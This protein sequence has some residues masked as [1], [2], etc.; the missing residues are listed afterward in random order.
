[1]QLSC[2]KLNSFLECPRTYL[3]ATMYLEKEDFPY[4]HTGR[5][6]HAIIQKH[7]SRKELDERLTEKLSKY[8]FPVVEEKDFDERLKFKLKFGDDEFIGFLDARNDEQKVFSDIKISTTLWTMKKFLDLTQRKV[9]Q[10][11]YPDYSFVGITAKPDLSE[12][13]TVDLPNRPK[14]AEYAR[15][16]ILEGFKKVKEGAKTNY[17]ENPNANC[18]RCVY[19]RS[20]D[21]SKYVEN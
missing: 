10:L 18:F 1:M 13:Y 21:K 5:E 6:G 12:V 14:D 7:I 4:F 8:H 2:S 15:N 11:A 16:W 9:Y 17:A 3:N 20:C 19:R